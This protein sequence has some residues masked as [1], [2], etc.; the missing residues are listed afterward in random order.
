MGKAPVRHQF[1]D[2]NALRC[3]QDLRQEGQLSSHLLGWQLSNG[4][5]IQIDC[6]SLDRKDPGQG[7]EQGRFATTVG[8][9]DGGD[10]F[11]GN[12]GRQGVNDNPIVVCH[13][14]G[15]SLNGCHSFPPLIYF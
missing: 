12:G 15:I 8:T 9:D 10:F 14:D 5:P 11:L 3:L 6:S 4:L 13:S 2:R 1:V 7:L